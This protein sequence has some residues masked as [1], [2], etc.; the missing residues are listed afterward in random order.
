[1]FVME[2]MPRYTVGYRHPNPP[3]HDRSASLL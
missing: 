2:Q 1:M 3:E